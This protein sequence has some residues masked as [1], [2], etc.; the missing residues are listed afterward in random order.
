MLVTG[1]RVEELLKVCPAIALFD[2]VVAENGA[3][4]YDPARR[5]E[6]VLGAPVP[7]SLVERLRERS[8]APLEVGKVLVA[9]HDPHG[10]VVFDV[11]RELGLELQVIVNRSSI[12]VLPPG[13]NKATG[14]EVALHKLGLSQHEAVAIGDAEN[15]HSFLRYCECGVAVANAVPSIKAAAELVTDPEWVRRARRLLALLP[16]AGSS[17]LLHGF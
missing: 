15:D 6:V 7:K 8:V 17:S 14:L 1:R 13:I 3:V 16:N 11:I 10:A 9:T 12:M 4:V 2:L 5:E